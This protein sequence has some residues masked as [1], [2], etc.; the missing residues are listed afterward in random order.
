MGQTKL[1]LETSGASTRTLEMDQHPQ[2][3]PEHHCTQPHCSI[4]KHDTVTTAHPS[5][6]K[7]APA[8]YSPTSSCSP[9][10]DSHLHPPQPKAGPAGRRLTPPSSYSPQVP[11]RPW[12]HETHLGTVL[13]D[14]C[15]C[16]QRSRGAMAMDGD[17]SGYR[18][19]PRHVRMKYIIANQPHCSPA[20]LD[21]RQGKEVLISSLWRFF[22]P[23]FDLS[24]Q[25]SSTWY[26]R[27][28]SK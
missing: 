17:F 21:Q 12:Q 11:P 7:D 9:S 28:M 24:L 2:R 20:S 18:T 27:K 22:S 13:G 23:F 3:L 25:S 6:T 26:K 10:R 4:P 14:G 5:S 8:A 16:M 19:F 1:L 15:S